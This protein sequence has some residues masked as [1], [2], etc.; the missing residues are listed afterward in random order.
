MYEENTKLVGSFYSTDDNDFSQ[1][2]KGLHESMMSTYSLNPVSDIGKIVAVEEA[3]ELYIQSLME[4]VTKESFGGDA[5]Q[6]RTPEKLHQLL[7]NSAQEILVESSISPLQPVVGI[8]LPVLKKSF[9][10]GNFKDVVPAEVPDKP[11]VRRTFERR[12]LQDNDGKKYYFPD[13]FY[14]KS[15]KEI[16]SKGK[17]NKIYSGWLP[18][19]NDT[20]PIADLNIMELSGG[21]IQKRDTIALDFA[22]AA[23][24][25][26]VG[27][28]LVTK[29][30]NVQPNQ[31]ANNTFNAKVEHV[32]EDGT[33]VTDVLFGSVDYRTGIVHVS[34]SAGKIKKVQFG[35]HLS[36]E[37]NVNSPDIG[38]E[39][40]LVEWKIADGVRINA[41][42]TLEEA[43]DTRNLFDIDV[44]T[45]YINT[46]SELLAQTEDSDGFDYLDTRFAEWESDESRAAPFG[47]DCKFTESRLFKCVPPAGIPITS[48]Q[49]IHEQLKF[50]LSRLID[51]MKVKLRNKNLMFVMYAHPN[52]ISLITDDVNWVINQDTK[53]GGIR[54]DYK[55]GVYTANENRVHVVSTLKH[56]VSE[57]FRIVAIPT[58]EETITF[59]QLKYAVS[60]SSAYRNPN[61]DKVPNIMGT[62]RYL[63]IDVL[64]IQS[65]M[66]VEDGGYSDHKLLNTSPISQV[67][68]PTVDVPG[69][70]YTGSQL[71]TVTSRTPGVSLYY[72]I[73]G[74]TPTKE[75]TAVPASGNVTI[76]ASATLKVIGYRDDMIASAVTTVAYVI[77]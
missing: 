30:V 26:E 61:V 3:R 31:S 58:D 48:A 45:D 73:D 75:S 64:P 41:P 72:T 50:N 28:E 68:T 66:Y 62:S 37:N 35:G 24:K 44:S 15:Y 19:G 9:L 69:G 46:I 4:D 36:N 16:M 18:S 27:A 42:I 60:I 65:T 8:T 13:I 55:F 14:D 74:S 51:V 67:I 39:R 71:I 32:S 7:E 54:L 52:N 47:Y 40:T 11:I 53:V 6:S 25:L 10:T 43:K 12:F 1:G 2:I 5:Y 21:T 76:S 34:S 70:T 77:E 57:G 33:V 29:L 56:P 38:R 49:Y 63:T 59:K 22:V 17:G 23:V 20:L